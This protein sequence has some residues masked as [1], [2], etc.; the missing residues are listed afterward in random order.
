[1]RLIFTAIEN[2]FAQLQRRKK[3][4][5]LAAFVYKAKV[6]SALHSLIY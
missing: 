1:M 3:N 6:S 5:S 4:P 2:S